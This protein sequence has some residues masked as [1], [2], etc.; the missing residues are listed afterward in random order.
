M[1]TFGCALA[2]VAALGM[3]RPEGASAQGLGSGITTNVRQF[4]VFRGSRNVGH[5]RLKIM[6][7]KDL[8]ILDEELS[9]PISVRGK[10]SEA[11]AESQV[12][13]RGA[14]RP[15]PQRGK[16][17][18]Y[19]GTF[20]I[21]DGTVEFTSAADGLT[22]KAEATG[23]ADL[24]RHPFNTPRT[25]E[26]QVP[27]PGEMVLTRA[28]MLY[29]APRLL[30][31]PGKIENVTRLAFPAGFD[32]PALI[33]ASPDCVLQRH[34]ATPEGTADITLHRVFAG[35]N[36]KTMMK[37]TVDAQNQVVEFHFPAGK[38]PAF[39]VRPASPPSDAKPA[40]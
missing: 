4:D 26:K 5:I 35:G 7:V 3:L 6:A 40:K 8:V 19:V 29:F 25:W 2:I 36:I 32:W 12:V 17:T 10:T 30:P 16:L 14:T 15:L 39:T 28:A 34:P 33:G 1:R 11:R 21:M 27:V 24:E 31:K 18:T 9:V 38:G 20:K 37:L 13:L 23:Y 22:A